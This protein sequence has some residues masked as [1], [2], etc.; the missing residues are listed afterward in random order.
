MNYE[1]LRERTDWD[2]QQNIKRV[3]EKG[4]AGQVGGVHV[5]RARVKC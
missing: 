5:A 4:L 2:V 3:W 1:S